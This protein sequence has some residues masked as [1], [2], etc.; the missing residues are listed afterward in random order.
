MKASEKSAILKGNPK[1][2]VSRTHYKFEE[3]KKA[4]KGEKTPVLDFNI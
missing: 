3:G 1:N 4:W 2:R